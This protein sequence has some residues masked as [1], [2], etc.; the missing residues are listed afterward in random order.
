MGTASITAR[1]RMMLQDTG[2]P[3]AA[4]IQVDG[5]SSVFDLPVESISSTTQPVVAFNGSI[6]KYNAATPAY[7]ID[8]KHGV[9]AF[10]NALTPTGA[11]LAVQ[12][13]TYD[14]FDDDEVAQAVTDAFNLHVDDQDPLPVIDPVPGQPSISSNEEYLVSILAA[15]ELL[16]FRSTDASQTID[17]HTP[18]GVFIPRSERFRQIMDQIQALQQQ[19]KSMAGALG[20]GLWRIQVLNQRR[21]SLTTNRLVP[22]FR[23]QEYNHPYT[24]FYPTAALPGSLVTIYG[25]YFTPT[26]SITFGGVP[27]VSFTVVSD[28]EITVTVPSNAITGQIGIITPYGVVLSTAEF[29]VGEPPPFVL[30]GPEM[31]TPPIPPGL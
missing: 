18:E 30:Y 5:I 29:V 20:V 1:T 27:A 14:Y 13:T 10:P 11:T 22:I 4:T 19:Y 9:I 24:G 31:V 16:W 21:V 26:T 6:I 12:G 23:D 2:T 25:K 7:T 8:Y 3:F 17:I 15:V 28:T